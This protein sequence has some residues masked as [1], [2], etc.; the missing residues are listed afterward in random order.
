MP[1]FPIERSITV[2]GLSVRRK[3][4]PICPAFCL[5]DY[6]VQGSTLSAA[7]LDLKNGTARRGQDSHR[8]YCSLYV[9]LSRLQSF[10]GLHLLEKISF[11]DL[12]FSPDPDLIVE[13]DRLRAL[14]AKTL[15]AWA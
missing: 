15:A 7:I 13:M 14:E 8:K 12:R 2:K 6:K 1:I 5:T 9:Q 11:D 10:H 3:Q 4:I